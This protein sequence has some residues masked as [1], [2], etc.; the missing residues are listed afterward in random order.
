MEI[1]FKFGIFNKH[2]LDTDN[3]PDT[4]RWW[5]KQEWIKH[6]VWCG[7]RERLVELVQEKMAAPPQMLFKKN[8]ARL[9]AERI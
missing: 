5:R 6:S 8:M 4:L 1:C 7:C 2:M 3:L 9:I